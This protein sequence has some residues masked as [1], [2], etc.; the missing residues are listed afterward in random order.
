MTIVGY[1]GE[2]VWDASKPNG[3]PKKLLDVSRIQSLGWEAKTSLD[4][5]LE[6]T[7]SWYQ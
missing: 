2:I 7:I 4:E 3:T 5:G 6:K 1:E